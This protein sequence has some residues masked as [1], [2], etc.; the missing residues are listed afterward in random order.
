MPGLTA[1]RALLGNSDEALVGV[2]RYCADEALDSVCA[3]SLDGLIGV[4]WAI[5]VEGRAPARAQHLALDVLWLQALAAWRPPTV[6]FP[7]RCAPK[8]KPALYQHL[9]PE[10]LWACCSLD[11]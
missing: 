10:P 8:S 1:F 9:A 5:L 7:A 11:C 2:M 6:R 4:L 3:T